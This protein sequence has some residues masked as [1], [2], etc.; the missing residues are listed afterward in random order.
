ML[1]AI[2]NELAFLLL[3]TIVSIFI[4]IVYKIKKLIEDKHF[5]KR[6]KKYGLRLPEKVLSRVDAQW[7]IEHLNNIYLKNGKNKDNFYYRYKYE[8]K[9]FFKNK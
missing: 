7:E 9:K 6:I 3:I 8:L 4:V 5:K 1:D 2:Q